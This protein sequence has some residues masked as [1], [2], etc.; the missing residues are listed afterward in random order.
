MI[1]LDYK[2][3]HHVV[4]GLD[5]ARG[6]HVVGQ[7]AHGRILGVVARNLSDLQYKIGYR[8]TVSLFFFFFF[9]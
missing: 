2:R 4:E 3:T 5:G 1:L 8:A 9:E 7:A 6:H